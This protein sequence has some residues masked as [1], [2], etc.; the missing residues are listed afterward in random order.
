MSFSKRVAALAVMA[1]ITTV[2]NSRADFRES[3]PLGPEQ[4][5]ISERVMLILRGVANAEQPRG[6]L[7]EAAALEYARRIG[8]RGEV[9]DSAADYGAGSTQ[10]RMA[11][12]R[13]RRDETVTAIYGFSGGGYNARQIWGQLNATE[14]ERI[15]K[16]VVVGSPGVEEWQFAGKPDVLIKLDPPEGHMAGPKALLEALDPLN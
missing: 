12:G 9:L 16:L 2:V 4:Q 10:V 5:P 6:A 3:Q 11:L 7:D 15:R 1:T 8:F 14:R 13:I